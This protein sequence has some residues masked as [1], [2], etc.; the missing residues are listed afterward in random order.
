MRLTPAEG[1]RG[2]SA[3]AAPSWL[4]GLWGL[5]PH[6]QRCI[7]WNREVLKRELGLTEHDI[8]DIPQLFSLKD[9]YA[10]AFFPDMVR[11][12]REVGFL[13]PWGPGSP[14][15]RPVRGPGEKPSLSEGLCRAHLWGQIESIFITSSHQGDF[16]CLGALCPTRRMPRHL[17]GG[18]HGQADTLRLEGWA[19]N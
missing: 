2:P 4:P 3:D 19:C 15:G 14:G 10:E 11:V 7:D 12:P 13:L 5:S 18:G 16:A 1:H 9:A 6:P 17:V 8:V